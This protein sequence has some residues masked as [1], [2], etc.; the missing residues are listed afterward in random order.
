MVEFVNSSHLSE[1]AP[2]T[3]GVVAAIYL[4]AQELAKP[5]DLRLSRADFVRAVVDLGREMQRD[6]T[7]LLEAVIVDSYADVSDE[8]FAAYMLFLKSAAGK[9]WAK[10]SYTAVHRYF[11]FTV[12]GVVDAV[13][14]R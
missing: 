6:L 5:E 4:G 3:I 14:P 1:L 11:K 8:D 2:E 12:L 13:A 10:A 7:P 9:A